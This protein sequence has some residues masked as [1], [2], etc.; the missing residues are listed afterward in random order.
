MA[1]RPACSSSASGTFSCT[2]SL[3]SAPFSGTC[4]WWRWPSSCASMKSNQAGWLLSTHRATAGRPFTPRVDPIGFFFASAGK[5]FTCSTEMP[6]AH[7][8]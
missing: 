1:Y 3:S 4:L 7:S 6:T 2:V 5:L 8:R